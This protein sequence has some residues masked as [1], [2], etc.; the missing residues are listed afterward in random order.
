MSQPNSN[1]SPAPAGE[2]WYITAFGEAYLTLYAHRNQDDA[3]RAVDFAVAELALGPHTPTLDLCCGAGRHM[4]E[5]EARGVPVT[6]VDLSGALLAAARQAGVRGPLIEADAR[7]VPL[8]DGSFTRGLSLFT[9]FGY[10]DDDGENL[11][12]LA[13][14]GRLLT[15]GGLALLDHINPA[16]LR[17]NLVPR[18]VDERPDGVRVVS[19]RRIDGELRRV[20]KTVE[21]RWPD[22]RS[23]R[24][25]E[26]VRLFEPEELDGMLGAAGFDVVGRRGDFTGQDFDGATSPRQVVTARRR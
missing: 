1:P 8:A 22:G 3:R 9:S 13:E 7:Q 5:L 16:W 23:H 20:E 6:G 14:L 12:V 17:A 10:F 11:R 24:H 25:R 21:A 4:R 19:E 26:S 2:P 18:S 15:P